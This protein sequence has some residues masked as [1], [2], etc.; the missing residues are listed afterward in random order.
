MPEP[1]IVRSNII[2]FTIPIRIEFQRWTPF[3]LVPNKSVVHER[4]RLSFPHIGVC[5]EIPQWLKIW[6][7]APSLSK[8][9]VEKVAEG[10]HTRSRDIWITRQIEFGIKQ[11]RFDNISDGGLDQL[12]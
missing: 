3:F 4:L 1:A 2:V 9:V 12:V 5:L 10:I 6:I 7:W 11:S 8:S